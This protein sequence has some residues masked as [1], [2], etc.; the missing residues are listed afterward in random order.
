M[1]P[2]KL[3]SLHWRLLLFGPWRSGALALILRRWRRRLA[4]LIL[5]QPD[6]LKI[7]RALRE[8]TRGCRV[9]ARYGSRAW[10]LL[11][12]M[13]GEQFE[14]PIILPPVVAEKPPPGDPA[15]KKAE[16]GT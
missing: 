12:D 4:Y 3:S 2:Q 14:L 11:D 16:A 6:R 7:A 13:T 9:K 8:I 15:E 10:M 1:K 5:A